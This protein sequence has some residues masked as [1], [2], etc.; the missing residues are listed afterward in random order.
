M[1]VLS[2]PFF[3]CPLALLPGLHAK[4][5]ENIHSLPQILG[6]TAQTAYLSAKVSFDIFDL[7]QIRIMHSCKNR[8]GVPLLGGVGGLHLRFISSEKKPVIEWHC[9]I[10]DLTILS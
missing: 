4:T 3:P 10:R 2:R 5:F 8:A 1:T 6:S 9:G 7:I